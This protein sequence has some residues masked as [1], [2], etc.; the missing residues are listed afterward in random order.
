LKVFL[1]YIDENGETDF[2]NNELI[3]KVKDPTDRQNLYNEAQKF[4]DMGNAAA[5]SYT[6]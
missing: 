5:D 4:Y 3:N 2:L 6:K 1:S